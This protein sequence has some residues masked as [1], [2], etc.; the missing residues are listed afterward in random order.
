ARR[1][2]PPNDNPLRSMEGFIVIRGRENAQAIYD[3]SLVRGDSRSRSKHD[4]HKTGRRRRGRN[5][6][7]VEAPQSEQVTLVSTR[8][9][10][11]VSFPLHCLQWRGGWIK[12]LSR[13][14]SCSPALKTNSSPQS[15]HL[16]T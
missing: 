6:T 3:G 15:T 11:L 2:D 5:G 14:K 10:L 8:P 12:P 13:K 7:T 9:R 16:R 1:K 4:R